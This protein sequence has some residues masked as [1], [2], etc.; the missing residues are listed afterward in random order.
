MVTASVVKVDK[1]NNSQITF[2]PGSSVVA[3]LR[4]S[5]GDEQDLSVAQ[6]QNVVEKW[7]TEHNITL[8]RVFSDV[9]TPG[10]ST[11]G[12]SAFKQMISHFHNVN[13]ADKGVIIWKFSRFSRD[14][15]DAQFYRADLRRRG[16]IV[17]SIQDNIPDTTDGRIYEALLDWM[18]NKFLE[19][20][21]VD[22]KRGL[23]HI[24]RE[25]GAV[26]GTPPRG[27]KREI[28]TIGIRRDGSP[29]KVSRWVPDP[30]WW[31]ICRR[32]WELRSTGVP[33]R[34]IHK[35]LHI[36]GSMQSYTT[37]FTN[38]IYLGELHYGEITIP[39][40]TDPMIT[41]EEW[42]AVQFLNRKN[43]VEYDPMKRN[44]NPHHPRRIS[45][46]FLLSGLIYCVRCGSLLNGEVLRFKNGQYLMYYHCGNAHR[47]LDCNAR[48]IPKAAI[49][50]VVIDRLREYI[51]DPA[52]IAE[53]DREYAIA[54]SGERDKIHEEQ[55][56]VKYEISELQRKMDNI[57]RQ[58]ADDPSPSRTL[59]TLIKELEQ[60]E[61][62]KIDELERL[63]SIE[64][65]ETVFIGSPANYARLSEKFTTE[66]VSGDPERIK[67]ILR[68]L[69]DRISAERDGDYIRGMIYFF[70]PELG[71]DNSTSSDEL[72][73]SMNQSHRRGSSYTHINVYNVDFCTTLPHK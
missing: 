72:Y 19:D 29:H 43:S 4:D 13:C 69:I 42:D 32:A 55:K 49:E 10:S 3:Y 30:E 47:N 59:M 34:Q 65:R 1:M 57:S 44:Q 40:Y 26:P 7:C 50:K 17:Y 64:N 14:I 12:R 20:L 62:K 11:I 16:Y 31:N 24:V 66:L 23:H 73:M 25:Y 45:S 9:A 18:N 37:F 71:E 51:L 33:I 39:D 58:I 60:Q 56:K 48:R 36:F 38:R 6:Q 41:K 68:G 2:P 70:N 53:R 28:T 52:L 8:S 46:S 21:S 35:E 67:L 61:Q 22:V 15:D 5:G 63:R 54:H 27:F